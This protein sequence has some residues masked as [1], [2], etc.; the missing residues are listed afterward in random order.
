MKINIL[1]IVSLILFTS[2]L[3]YA[4]EEG[5]EKDKKEGE[6]KDAEIVIEKDREI[7]LPEAERKFQK[8]PPLPIPEYDPKLSFNF[9][10]YTAPF[11]PVNKRVRVLT[12]KSDPLKKLY[13]NYVK[14]GF[15]NFSSPYG[16]IY[17]NNKREEKF[18]YG[19]FG[20][21]LSAA[22]GPVDDENSG[23]SSN[24]ARVYGNVFTDYLK[25]S[26]EL[27]YQRDAYH[28]YGYTQP[29]D[30]DDDDIR[31]IFNRF[32]AS[33]ALSDL[34]TENGLDY[35]INLFY[36]ILSDEFETD[37]NQ[38]GVESKYAYELSDAL[39][40]GLFLDYYTSNLEF[41]GL[42]VTRN[43]FR[44]TPHLSFKKD[45]LTVLGGLN[46][47]FEDDE[48]PNA[49]EFHVFPYVKADY[50]INSNFSVFAAL[51]GDVDRITYSSL[52]LENPFIGQNS[53]VFNTIENINISGGIKGKL[54]SKT[55]YSAGLEYANLDNYYF[56]A[57]GQI[58]STRFDA[59][60]GENIDRFNIYGELTFNSDRF[61]SN[62]RADFFTYETDTLADAFHRPSFLLSGSLNYN[63]N[64]KIILSSDLT[65]ISG[66]VGF[67]AQSRREEDLETIF[68]LSLKGEYLFSKKVSF[69]LS[70]ENLISQEYEYYLNYPVRATRAIGGFSYLF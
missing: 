45:Q 36:E 18:S 42:D 4:Q 2:G 9:G 52:A 54:G 55:A 3:T 34:S 51:K 50:E 10:D 63:I 21:H 65:L 69:F 26:G 31:Q 59:L 66:L 23:T 64:E 13:G 16:E 47:V 44:I 20:R 58:D 40:V 70:L 12:T 1:I 7:T 67:N 37:E 14:A 8:I 22:N 29:A 33:V 39:S 41:S 46:G 43:F 60:Y 24:I 49:D 56:F 11:N 19:F 35:A 68:D 30:V 25:L 48:A 17:L 38:F 32:K 57:N 6:V 61:Y 62:I 15:G 28:Y 5:W 53:P 27:D